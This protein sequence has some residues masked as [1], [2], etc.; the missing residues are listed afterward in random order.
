MNPK[1][2]IF[3][4]FWTIQDSNR[5]LAVPYFS[6]FNNIRKKEYIILEF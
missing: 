5:T 3:S 1:L 6:I 4:A 2:Y